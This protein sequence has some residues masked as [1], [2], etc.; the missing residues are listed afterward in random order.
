MVSLVRRGVPMRQVARRFGISLPTVQFWCRRAGDRRLDR[1]DFSDRPPVC[2]RPAN[3]CDEAIEDLIL[4]LRADLKKH[5]DL[6]E[7]GAAAILRQLNSIGVS[8][9]PS[10]RT[11]G[12]VLER[13]GALDGRRR[14]R[15]LPPPIGWH[16]PS[17]ASKTAELDSF[18]IVEDLAIE[19]GPQVDVLNG[20]SIF[21]GLPASFPSDGITAETAMHC[22]L[23]HWR[24]FGLPDFAQF[25][26]DT[27]FL[28]PQNHLDVLGRVPRMCLSLSVIPVF[29]PP[30]EPGFQNS[31]ESFNGRW[32]SKVWC[33]FHFPSL[34]ALQQ[35]SDR[36]IHAVRERAA[37]RQEWAPIRRP[38]P[39]PWT[40]D[41]QQAPRGTVIFLRRAYAHGNVQFFGRQFHV[42]SHWPHRLVRAEVLLSENT[43]LFFALR[44]RSPK[45]QPILAKIPFSLKTRSKFL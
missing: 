6:G 1:V 17:L 18:D 25:D 19:R 27:R 44:R 33:R 35:Q 43:I 39:T 34:A 29:A 16:L 42:S 20:I 8:P 13:R 9:R 4:S 32:Q 28:G 12:R 41:L 30:R 38:F 22:I 36:F 45:D 31:I 40:L 15:Y 3:R 21:G 11:I 26:N 5:S 23:D 24:E 37:H 10:L 14:I 2:S 7:F